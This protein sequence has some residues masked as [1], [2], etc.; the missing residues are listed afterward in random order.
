MSDTTETAVL[1]GG[2]F[3]PAQE[4]LRYREG[5]ISTRVGYT[6]GENDTRRPTTIPVTLRRSRSSSIPNGLLTG[7]SCSSFFR[8]TDPILAKTLSDRLPL[9]DLLYE[10]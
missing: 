3:W 8:S 5:V 1:A 4:L 9:R 10:Q 7:P 2:C 6:G